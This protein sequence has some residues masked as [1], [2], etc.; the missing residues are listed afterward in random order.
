[1]SSARGP[2]AGTTPSPPALTAPRHGRKTLDYFRPHADDSPVVWRLDRLGRSVKDILIIADNLHGRGI[3]LR[4]LTGGRPTVMD[5]DKLAAAHARRA[6][7][8][9]VSRASIYRHLA[10]TLQPGEPEQAPTQP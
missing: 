4:V 7:A 5:A 2:A 3:G 10:A 6:K 8:L 1:M 9:G